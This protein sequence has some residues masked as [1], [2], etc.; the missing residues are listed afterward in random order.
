M[1]QAQDFLKKIRES[2]TSAFSSLK[3]KATAPE[4]KEQIA[5]A[6]TKIS[7]A[8]KVAGEKAG[9]AAKVAAEKASAT[10]ASVKDKTV[11]LTRTVKSKIEESK[12]EA[13]DKKA[14]TSY[15]TQYE[16]QKNSAAHMYNK[17]P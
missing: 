6:K 14:H 17:N 8:A 3:T 7:D 11:E 13:N 10:S 4:T 2:V 16:D 5:Q 12:N 1:A 15:G 9:A